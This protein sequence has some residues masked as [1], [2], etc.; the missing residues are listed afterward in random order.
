MNAKT[1]GGAITFAAVCLFLPRATASQDNRDNALQMV[2]GCLET[3]PGLNTYS[4]LDEN[5]KLWDIH[6]AKIGFANYVGKRVCLGGAVPPAPRDP[7]VQQDRAPQ[8]HLEVTQV[9]VLADSCQQ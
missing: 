1:L 8:N 9:T 4:L 5:G 7:S 6:S 3:G 2:S